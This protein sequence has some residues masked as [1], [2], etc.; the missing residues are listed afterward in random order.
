MPDI[1]PPVT[2]VQV[3]SLEG[4]SP[5]RRALASAPPDG[6]LVARRYGRRDYYLRRLLAISDAACL[7]LAM[8]LAMSIASQAQDHPWGEFLL[9]GLATL[10]GWVVLFKV[11]GLYER[12]AKRLSHSTLDDIPSLFH[13]LLLGCLLMWCWFVVAA[14][15]KLTFATILVFGGLAMALVLAGRVATRAGFLRLIAPERVLLIGTGETA[16]VL[17]R[18]CKP[19]EACASTRSGWSAAIARWRPQCPCR[20]WLF[21]ET[22][23]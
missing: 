12:D 10:P 6:S 7:A 8:V 2:D 4:G 18:R 19:R 1:A 13:A 21:S 9:Y 14:P 17:M 16:G 5:P 11:Y 22:W 3:A 23:T 20:C 15:F